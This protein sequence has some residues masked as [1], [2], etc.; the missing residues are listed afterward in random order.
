MISS[1]LITKRWPSGK[2]RVTRWKTIFCTRRWW[3]DWEKQALLWGRAETAPMPSPGDVSS[4]SKKVNWAPSDLTGRFD[5]AR[6]DLT[7]VMHHHVVSLTTTGYP[8][9]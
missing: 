1:E 7:W 3:L 4:C 5:R 6:S 2:A 9:T 8:F